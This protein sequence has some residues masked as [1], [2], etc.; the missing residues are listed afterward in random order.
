M[1]F[2]IY[3]MN[4]KLNTEEIDILKRDFN[5]LD[6]SEYENYFEARKKFE[7]ENPGV[8]FRNNVWWWRPLWDYVCAVCK[9]VITIDDAMGGDSNSGHIINENTTTEMAILLYKEVKEGNHKKYE[10]QYTKELESIPLEDCNLCDGTGHRTDAIF[11]GTCNKC[12]GKGKVKSFQAAYPFSAENVE[13]F[14]LFLS[15][16][17]G[18]QIC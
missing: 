4:P 16:S 9:D 5:D 7:K 11:N 2:D 15:E 6:E 1:G 13:E 12:E 8:Y 17:G 18:I 3:G 14:L 10:K